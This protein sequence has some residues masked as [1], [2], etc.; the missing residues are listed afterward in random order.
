MQSSLLQLL[1]QASENVLNNGR[2]N[3]IFKILERK[4]YH[5][6]DLL[7]KLSY[8]LISS[9]V[10]WAVSAISIASSVLI[11]TSY[12]SGSSSS[13]TL[14]LTVSGVVLASLRV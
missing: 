13:S 4:Y 6:Y 2:V 7:V 3:V 9:I 5:G 12:A 1:C 8:S 14:S 10:G 11:T